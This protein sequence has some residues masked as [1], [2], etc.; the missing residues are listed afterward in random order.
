MGEMRTLARVHVKHLGLLGKGKLHED[1]IDLHGHHYDLTTFKKATYCD[2]CGHFLWGVKEQGFRCH[3]CGRVVCMDCAH[4]D[5]DG[6]ECS[7]AC[8][9]HDFVLQTFHHAT[10]C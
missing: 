6:V 10:W 9:E 1:H 5:A 3:S 4:S 8:R 2:D 7:G